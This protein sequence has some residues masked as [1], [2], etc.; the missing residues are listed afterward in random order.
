LQRITAYLFQA[1]P[2]RK[3]RLTGELK[4]EEVKRGLIHWVK[5][6]QPQAFAT[7]IPS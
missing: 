2:V 6:I 1:A 4:A 5:I 7:E 3:Y